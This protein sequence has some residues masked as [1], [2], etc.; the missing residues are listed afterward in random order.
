MTPAKKKITKAAPK[1]K[2][3]PQTAVPAPPPPPAMTAP[4]RRFWHVIRKS[5]FIGLLFLVLGVGVL[6]GHWFYHREWHTPSFV[7]AGIMMLLG[8]LLL[9]PVAVKDALGTLAGTAKDLLPF[10]RKSDSNPPP[11]SGQ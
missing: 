11:P 9:D 7:G 5:T 10:A 3:C 2:P 8:A 1:K 6:G 4:Q